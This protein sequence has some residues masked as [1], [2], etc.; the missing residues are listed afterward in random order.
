[1]LVYDIY[2]YMCVSIFKLVGGFKKKGWEGSTICSLKTNR[3][4]QKTVLKLT[5]G[6]YAPCEPSKIDHSQAVEI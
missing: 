6:G 4:C 1:M 2:I 5:P 3:C